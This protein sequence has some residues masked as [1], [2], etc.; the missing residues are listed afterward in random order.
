MRQRLPKG[1]CVPKYAIEI[2]A[3]SI[4]MTRAM[5]T[6]KKAQRISVTF[7][8]RGELI[9]KSRPEFVS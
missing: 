1:L 4:M 2:K 8:E 5:K 6:I 9:V 3:I 7:S